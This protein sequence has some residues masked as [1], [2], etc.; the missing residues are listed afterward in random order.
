MAQNDVGRWE[1]HSIG[2]ASSAQQLA[3]WKVQPGNENLPR[4][5]VLLPPLSAKFALVE[6]PGHERLV[7]LTGIRG[8]AES[9][10]QIM[11]RP[12][13]PEDLIPKLAKAQVQVQ[14]D[15]KQHKSRGPKP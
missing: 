13:A 4:K 10:E 11:L 7:P 9:R 1:A 6:T 8:F 15:E 14:E 2:E 5:I 3:R 12:Y